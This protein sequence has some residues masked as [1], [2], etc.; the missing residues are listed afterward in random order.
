VIDLFG[1]KPRR[2]RRTMM[3]VVDAGD[4]CD[5]QSLVIAKL[6]CSECGEETDWIEFRTVTEAKRGIPCP[7]CNESR[8]TEGNRTPI[9][10]DRKGVNQ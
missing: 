9:D 8:G 10:G 4:S 3:H 7:A 5:P 1:E 6:A 2:P